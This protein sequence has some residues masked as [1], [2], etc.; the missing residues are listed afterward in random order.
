MLGKEERR[1]MLRKEKI[2][3]WREILDNV[4]EEEKFEEI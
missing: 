3:K 4:E 1:E 2:N